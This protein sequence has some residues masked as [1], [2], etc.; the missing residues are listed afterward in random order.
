MLHFAITYGIGFTSG[1][2]AQ[3]TQTDATAGE[4]P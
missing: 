3:H 1:P 2:D 4:V